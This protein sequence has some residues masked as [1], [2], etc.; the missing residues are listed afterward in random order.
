MKVW[1]VCFFVLFAGTELFKWLRSFPVP[2]PIYVLGGAF[3]AVVSNHD[4]IFGS[5]LKNVSGINL[6]E[7]SEP[8][9]KLESSAPSNS[10]SLPISD[11][12]KSS[13]E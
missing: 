10:V 12:E 9:P 3:L 1:L 8:L 11:E 6:V 4:K 5:Y 13:Q 7:L 2:L